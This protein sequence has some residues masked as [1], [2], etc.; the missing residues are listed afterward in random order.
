MDYQDP[1][2]ALKFAAADSGLKQTIEGDFNLVRVKYNSC[3]KETVLGKSSGRKEKKMVFF[4]LLFFFVLMNSSCE[5]DLIVDNEIESEETE[6]ETV[7]IT[8]D[9]Y[10]TVSDISNEL[11]S[12]GPVLVSGKN[13]SMTV[14]YLCDE[15]SPIET[16]LS[17][18]IFIR[19]SRFSVSQTSAVAFTDIA[20]PNMT[21][22][23]HNTGSSVPYEPNC[24]KTGDGLLAMFREGGI[25]GS[26]VCCNVD[27]FELI[28]SNYRNMTID[29]R[30]LDSEGLADVYKRLQRY[31]VNNNPVVVFTTR[32]IKT[33]GYY[34]SH[35]GDYYDYGVIV[36]SKNGVDWESLF[37][38][39]PISG[40]SYILEGAVGKDDKTGNLF[41]CARGDKVALYQYDSL[42][43]EK[44]EP[45]VLQGVTTSK[46]TFF[47]YHDDLYLI[48][49]MDNDFNFSN[50]RRNTANIYKVDGVSGNLSL[51]KAIKCK[52]G[53]AYHSIQVVN[54]EIWM[55]FQTDS[56]QIAMETQGRSNLALYKLEF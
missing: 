45:R 27:E 41:L 26:Y 50:G 13:G 4:L 40:M 18:T 55:V 56:R 29:G 15:D 32:I 1:Q 38:P 3:C 23:G 30:M 33:D 12:C 10:R 36:R 28:C 48:V 51:V 35:L 46:P 20:R 7:I 24:L 21:L 9:D 43:N 11:L 37:I 17:S 8:P 54:D 22:H 52:E 34:Y 39:S 25:N 53:C 6:K 2:Q 44:S 42:F 19:A 47:N 49:N 31:Q 5:K 16:D 14:V